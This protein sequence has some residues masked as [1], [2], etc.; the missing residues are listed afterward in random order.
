MAYLREKNDMVQKWKAEELE[1]HKQHLKVE[2]RKQDEFQ[3][4]QQAMIQMMAQQQQ[5]FQMFA[6]MQLQ[7]TQVILKLLEKQTK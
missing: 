5:Q 2:S 1:L 3:K 7:Q 6:S 4:Q